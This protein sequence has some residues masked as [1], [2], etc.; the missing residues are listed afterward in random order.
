M[1]AA[2]SNRSIRHY[3]LAWA[4]VA[5]AILALA[6]ICLIVVPHEAQRISSK[7]MEGRLTDR[8]A[9]VATGDG[10]PE[11]FGIDWGYW[12]SINPDIVGW[13]TIPKTPIDYPIV[14]AHPED[15][16]HYLNYDAYDHY[17]IYGCAYVDAGCSMQSPNVIVFAHNMGSGEDA[18]FT[19]LTD[20]LD[21]AYLA[22]HKQVIIQTPEGTYDLKAR[23]AESVSPYGFEKRTAFSSVE[24]LREFYL[25]LWGGADSRCAEPNADEVSQ[26]FTLI[27][28]DKGGSARAVVYAG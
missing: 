10:Q 22:E 20:Y 12:Q 11:V 26:L 2:R 9:P 3:V 21:P 23:A 7:P 28:C 5:V 25:E 18:M 1:T 16:T 4:G 17:N 6:A 19:T 8:P 13:I 14:Q 27:T 24:G 15:A